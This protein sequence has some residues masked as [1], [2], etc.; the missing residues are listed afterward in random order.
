MDKAAIIERVRR[1]ADAVRKD[2]DVKRV[3]LFGSYSKDS[4][5]EDSDI[6]VA[7]VVDC[8]EGDFLAAES[9]LFRLRRQIDSR[10]E[11][12]LLEASNDRSGFLE[13]ILKTGEVIYSAEPAA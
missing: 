4:P 7:V 12:V 6:D 5:R 8:V 10:I 3:I 9:K 1:Y 13:E 11:P 2:F